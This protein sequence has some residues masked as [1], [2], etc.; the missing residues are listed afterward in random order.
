MVNRSR[1]LSHFFPF[2]GREGPF[3]LKFWGVPYKLV[4]EENEYIDSVGGA[5][6]I[7]SK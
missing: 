7:I 6:A 1:E 4:S 3:I 5:L 2:L